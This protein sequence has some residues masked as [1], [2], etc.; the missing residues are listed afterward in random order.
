VELWASGKLVDLW[1]D[2]VECL[3]TEDFP[4]PGAPLPVTIVPHLICPP[5][6]PLYLLSAENHSYKQ[7]TGGGGG[8]GHGG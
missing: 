2:A 3:T 8:G 1:V 6:R 5:I 4:L 7:T